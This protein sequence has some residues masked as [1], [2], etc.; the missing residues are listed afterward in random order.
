MKNRAEDAQKLI[1][2][3]EFMENMAPYEEKLRNLAI[4][5]GI[6]IILCFIFIFY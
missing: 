2:N 4:V 3:A 5:V 6:L 1:E